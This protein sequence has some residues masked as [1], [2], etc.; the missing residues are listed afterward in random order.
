[1]GKP[2]SL[3]PADLGLHPQVTAEEAREPWESTYALSLE[4]CSHTTW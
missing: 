3:L 2:L 1:M 4:H